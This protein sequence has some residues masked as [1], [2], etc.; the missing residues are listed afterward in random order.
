MGAKCHDGRGHLEENDGLVT[1]SI[2][3]VVPEEADT[4]LAVGDGLYAGER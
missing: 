4:L 2:D 1:P 3:G